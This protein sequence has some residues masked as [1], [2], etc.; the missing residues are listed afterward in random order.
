MGA[1]QLVDCRNK[2][3]FA[4]SSKLVFARGARGPTHGS[5]EYAIHTF[6]ST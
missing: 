3:D 4:A 5:Q 6:Y 2:K 1:C